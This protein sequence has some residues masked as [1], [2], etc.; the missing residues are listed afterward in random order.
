M[1]TETKCP[2]NHVPG[3]GTSNRDWWPNQLPLDLLHQHSA[4]SNPMGA[5]FDYREAFRTLDF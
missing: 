2:I 5:D 1:A 3:G 4:A